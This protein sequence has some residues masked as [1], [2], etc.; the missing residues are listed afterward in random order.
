METTLETPHRSPSGYPMVFEIPRPASQ[1]RLTN[2]PLGIGT[3]IRYILAIPHLV[4]LYFL[5]L[6]ALVV[7]FIADF[8]ILFTGSYPQGM[9]N[10]V[11]GIQ[12]WNVNISAYIFGLRDEYP[13]F[14]TDAGRYPVTYDVEYPTGLN[15]ILNFPIFGIYIKLLLLIPHFVVLLFVY[16]AVY[17]VWFIAQFAILF[18][19]SYPEGMHRFSVGVLRWNQ[20]LQIYLASMTDKYPPFSTK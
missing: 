19:G 8:A 15:R 14:T 17:V 5:G 2:F 3:F 10:F 9:F 20:R 18:T 16:L 4:V 11:L 7:G 13:P 12:R 1:S 6:A